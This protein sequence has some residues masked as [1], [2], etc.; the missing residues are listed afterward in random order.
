MILRTIINIHVCGRIVKHIMEIFRAMSA[1]LRL[2]GQLSTRH[3]NGRSLKQTKA[4]SSCSGGIPRD[5]LII[6]VA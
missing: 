2:L 3:C 6:K 4:A 1:R 5:P